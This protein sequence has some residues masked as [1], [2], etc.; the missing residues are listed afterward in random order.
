MPVASRM[1]YRR[2]GIS[3][4]KPVLEND[5]RAVTDV[6]RVRRLR[7]VLGNGNPG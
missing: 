1:S 4:V 2:P 3:F 7:A 6:A 5:V